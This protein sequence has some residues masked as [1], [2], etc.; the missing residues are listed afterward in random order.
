MIEGVLWDSLYVN[1][2]PWKQENIDFLAVYRDEREAFFMK[3]QINKGQM[4]G[5]WIE[6]VIVALLGILVIVLI[7]GASASARNR[8]LREE[9]QKLYLEQKKTVEKEVREYLTAQG[10][11]NCGITLTRREYGENEEEYRLSIHHGRLNSLSEERKEELKEA[12][13]AYS[14]S[15]GCDA[16]MKVSIQ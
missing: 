14:K 7:L 11:Q 8:A 15:F 13:T 5:R 16:V 3:K 2:K 4:I 12:L 9:K 10:Y 1:I 6:M